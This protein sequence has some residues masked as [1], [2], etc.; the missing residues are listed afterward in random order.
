MDTSAT[1]A[2]WAAQTYNPTYGN[3]SNCNATSTSKELC[4][5]GLLNCTGL[6]D[7]G[8]LTA[9]VT[10]D[11]ENPGH[12][13]WWENRLEIPFSLFKQP[14]LDHAESPPWRLWRGNFYR[15]VR[16]SSDC[17]LMSYH[18][19][20]PCWYFLFRFA[21]I[22]S[23]TTSFCRYDYPYGSHHRHNDNKSYELTAWSPTHCG[24]YHIPAR[25]GVIVLDGKAL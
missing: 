15:C 9:H 13:Q 8:R 23:H 24:S 14:F 2:L 12:P 19:R 4:T 11:R 1:G 3:V 5:P 10:L 6:A 16:S 22:L 7:F 21:I 18:Q 17:E 20:V 25:F